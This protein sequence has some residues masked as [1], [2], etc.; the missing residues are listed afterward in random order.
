MSSFYELQLLIKTVAAF[1]PTVLVQ[2]DPL[3]SKRPRKNT[4]KLRRQ[5]MGVVISVSACYL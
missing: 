5:R 2:S 4:V 3:P 1:C